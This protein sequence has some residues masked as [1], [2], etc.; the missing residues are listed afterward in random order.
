MGYCIRVK[1]PIQCSGETE[2]KTDKNILNHRFRRLHSVTEPQPKHSTQITQ[3]KQIT[4]IFI[5]LKSTK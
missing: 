2:P 5:I 3:I 4:Q 1:I